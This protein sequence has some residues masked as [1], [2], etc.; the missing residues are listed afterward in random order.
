[1]PRTSKD[2]YR[3]GQASHGRVYVKIIHKNSSFFRG[4]A[5][6][7]IF[8]GV[9]GLVNIYGPVLWQEL[10]FQISRTIHA[11][12]QNE[13][14]IQS[15]SVTEIQR[16]AHEWGVKS[17]FSV[18]IPK[19]NA[20]KNIVANVDV[21]RES[22]YSKALKEG[23]AH[24]KGSNFPGQGNN[25]FLFAHS[26]D[27]ESNVSKYNASFYLLNK[28]ERGDDIYVYFADKK[29]KYKVENVNIVDSN[30]ISWLKETNFERLTLQTCY[31]PGTIWKRLIVTAL[32]V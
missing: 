32:P 13:L 11:D 25:I 28:L 6:G 19:I 26:T 31:P 22:E 21:A 24:A 23:V 18:V 1:M 14:R 7:L 2:I 10:N 30:D 15:N 16:E 5:I 27:I 4:A 12:R 29:F 9:M 20:S 17:Q 3:R 8:W